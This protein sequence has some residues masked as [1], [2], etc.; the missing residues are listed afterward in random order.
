MNRN[1]TH[2]VRYEQPSVLSTLPFNKVA[3]FALGCLIIFVAFKLAWSGWFSFRVFE[4]TGLE[5]KQS[6]GLGNPIGLI[7]F[8]IDGVCL[9]GIAG[10]AVVSFIRGA[11]G[12]L[13]GGMGQWM[14][15]ARAGFSATSAADATAATTARDVVQ[16]KAEEKPKQISTA[17]LVAVL[18][19]HQ[20]RIK[21]IESLHPELTPAP[22]PDPP[23]M[24]DLA[25]KIAELESEL[26][27]RPAA[28]KTTRRRT[29]KKKP[30]VATAAKVEAIS[31]E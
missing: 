17:K 10:F 24:E 18:N 12:P 16:P 22:E 3:Q 27:K 31:N 15:D 30:A 6:D 9:I 8:L 14:A 5:S 19:D 7:P 4:S 11:I 23:T 21:A 13:F 25:A 28:P 20:A 1:T 26:A 2:T 29:A